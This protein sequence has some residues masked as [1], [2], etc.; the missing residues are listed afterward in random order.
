MTSLTTMNSVVVT[1]VNTPSWTST[2]ALTTRC[3]PIATRDASNATPNNGRGN[4]AA[5]HEAAVLRGEEALCRLQSER[6]VQQEVS[7]CA[8]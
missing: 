3:L 4:T 1:T 5:G 6:A 8:E 7:P 2:R